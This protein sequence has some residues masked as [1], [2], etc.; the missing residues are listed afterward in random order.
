[1]PTVIAFPR[2]E[3]R[4]RPIYIR[5]ESMVVADAERGALEDAAV[6]LSLDHDELVA[7]ASQ[8]GADALRRNVLRIDLTASRLAILVD[9]LAEA[10]YRL[11]KAGVS[12]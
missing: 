2:P 4:F 5:P 1:M 7:L 3:E 8:T 12:S 11:E 9:L 10:R 6:I